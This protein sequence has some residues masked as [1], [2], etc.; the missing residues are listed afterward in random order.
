MGVGKGFALGW[1]STKGFFPLENIVHIDPD[2]F[3]GVMP[4]WDA[5]VE[6]GK[7]LG[8]PD[9]PG[10][11]CHRESSYMQELALEESLKRSQNIWVD[12]SLRNAVRVFEDVRERHPAY[13]IAI[14]E[15]TA[16]EHLVR[17]RVAERARR[18]GR[19][20]PE[21]TLTASIKAVER[22]VLT[23]M[24]NAD[25]LASIDNSAS[26]PRLR[27]FASI[28]RSGVWSHVAAR[29][30]H[31]LPS[32]ADFPKALAPFFLSRVRGASIELGSGGLQCIADGGRLQCQAG[33][34]VTKL[35][36]F[37]VQLSLANRVT[38]GTEA[39]H[40][41]GLQH[42]QQQQQPQQQQ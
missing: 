17:K 38:L 40:V 10:S 35:G 28:N 4:E 30:A 18:T 2:H 13:Q 5:Y 42:Q 8:D 11:Q 12:G 7:R 25:F 37:P 31:T 3:K 23:L 27:Y 24:P 20:I 21:A 15:V 33:T 1:M 32:P 26:T 9:I 39:R 41:A 6:H 19:S 29:F 36:R 16:P 34:V 14:F 22:S